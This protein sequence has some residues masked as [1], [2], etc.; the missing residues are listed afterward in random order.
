[1]IV[2]RKS[3]ISNTSDFDTRFQ[4]GNKRMDFFFHFFLFGHIDYDCAI[5][6]GGGRDEQ[7]IKKMSNLFE[8]V[9]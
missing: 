5:F 9:Y 1:M 2:H 7:K 6:G 4:L 3:Q 8:A